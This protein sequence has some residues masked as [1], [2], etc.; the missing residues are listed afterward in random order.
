MAHLQGMNAADKQARVLRL[1]QEE[2]QTLTAGVTCYLFFLRF[3]FPRPGRDLVLNP[4][5]T[6]RSY[7]PALCRFEGRRI[8]GVAIHSWRG[9]S[10]ALFAAVW[11]YPLLF[12]FSPHR[13]GFASPRT[14]L[15]SSIAGQA[16]SCHN[17]AI[18]QIFSA[19]Q[20]PARPLGG[21]SLPTSTFLCDQH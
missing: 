13:G 5:R 18:G 9:S 6:P 14:Q 7:S 4:A 11:S 10:D 19:V 2:G 12:C 3:A 16:V 20:G 1:A 17:G 15:A 21:T 8:S